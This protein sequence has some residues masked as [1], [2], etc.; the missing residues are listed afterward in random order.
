MN[1]RVRAAAA[2]IPTAGISTPSM[3]EMRNARS[4]GF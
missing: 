3:I 1:Y 4:T 2:V